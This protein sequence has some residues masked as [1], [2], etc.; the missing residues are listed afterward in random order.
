MQAIKNSRTG[1][2]GR[3]SKPVDLTK[4]K[5]WKVILVYSAPIILSYLLQQIY[6]LADAVICGQVLSAEEVAGVNDTY[7]L[8][9]VFLQFA[10]GCTAGF[11]VI[12]ARSVGCGEE[13]RVRTSF[14]SQLYLSAAISALLT[15]VSV[16]SLKRLLSLINVTPENISVYNAA[17]S[18][19]LIIFLGLFAQM[20]YNL[21]CGVLRAYGDSV[22]PLIFLVFST[23]LNIALDLLFLIPFKLGPAGAAAAT[24][25]AQLI[26]FAGCT[27]YTFLRYKNL[28]PD[29][30]EWHAD[31]KELKAHL[32][33]GLPLGTQFSIL[34][35][36]IIVMQSVVVKFDMA[37]N[38]IMV[39]GTP[40]QNG[41]G[42]ANKLIEFLM[43]LFM[44]LSS[45]ILGFNAQNLGKRD[46]E[47]IKRGT[48]QSLLIMLCFYVFC[49]AVGLLLTVN[50][51]YQH[52]F[53]S[54]DKISEK[55]LM[56]GDIF[57]YVDMTLYFFLGFLLVA[58]SAVQGIGKSGYVLGAGV[59]ELI[60]RVVICLVMPIAVNGGEIT[61]AASTAAFAATC[62]GDPGAWILGSAFLV[63]PVMKHIV[64][65]KY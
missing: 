4:G 39:A 26:S 15:A 55:S 34:A 12:T 27:A 43:P 17:Y 16:L 56:Y 23:V 19:C 49:L 51:T 3:L 46:T 63:M 35:V 52:I 25:L 59:A 50:G 31:I 8:T 6:I 54:A 62:F 41:F 45:G 14:V 28:K 64:G 47:R 38:G 10:F 20:G 65:K 30:S 1:F 58:R 7:P 44:G 57:I 11:S 5:P 37:E 33:Q 60:A 40:A 42:A 48:L 18:Y 22:T 61:A 29:R 13:H 2:F 32:K 21:V 24:V 9:F 53:M 36:G